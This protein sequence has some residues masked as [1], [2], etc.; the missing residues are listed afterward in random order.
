M[1]HVSHGRLHVA[2]CMLHMASCILH[3]LISNQ[4]RE[5]HARRTHALESPFCLAHSYQTA[6]QAIERKSSRSGAKTSGLLSPRD[7]GKGVGAESKCGQSSW[8]S[9][10]W[11]Q[12]VNLCLPLLCDSIVGRNACIADF[13]SA[14]VTIACFCIST[15]RFKH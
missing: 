10:A 13:H 15:L 2:C 14:L 4:K 8:L 11:L 5:A 9:L 6:L 1:L 3:E 12:A 7:C